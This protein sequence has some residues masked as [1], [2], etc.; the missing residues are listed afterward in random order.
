MH[1][2]RAIVRPPAANFAL[3][4]SGANNGPPDIDR[5]LDQH[6]RYCEALRDCGL[7][8]THVEADLDYPD[9]TFVED[10]A[11]VTGRGAILTRPGAPSRTGEIASVGE[12]LSQFYSDVQHIVAPGTVDGGDICQVDD[13]FLIGVSARTN[14]PGAEQ[15]A[16][17]LRRMNYTASILDIRA[18][19]SLLHLK[20]G[21][22]YLGDGVWLAAAGIQEEFL[23][24]G[25]AGIR[26]RI[27]VSAAESYAANCVR[28]NDTVLLA[29]GYPQLTAALEERGYRLV[30]LQMS[31][32][33]KMDGGLS[34]LSLRF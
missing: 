11:I 31:E 13:H 4:L 23:R 20:T 15:L 27:A 21:I 24:A 34:C 5:A 19:A 29:A 12:S 25:G 33:R 7:Q 30:T 18:S 6:G 9:G 16:E 2:T 26:E 10:A 3:G 14:Q 32:F 1:F 22:A 8:V 17:H 28:I